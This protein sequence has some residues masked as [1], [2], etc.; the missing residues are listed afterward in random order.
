MSHASNK[1]RSLKLWEALALSLGMVGPTLAMSGNAQGLIDSVGKALPIVFVLGL[2][3]VALIAYGFIRL[4]RFYNHAGS[5]YGLV[6]L[7]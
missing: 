2:I 1:K 3:G 6:G 7:C 4:T 5:A